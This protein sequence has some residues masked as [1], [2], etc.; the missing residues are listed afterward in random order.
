VAVNQCVQGP[1][2]TAGWT[3]S[4]REQS[5]RALDEVRLG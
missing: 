5:P 2:R 4:A 3:Q 1:L